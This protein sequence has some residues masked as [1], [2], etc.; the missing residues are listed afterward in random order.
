MSSPCVTVALSPR[1]GNSRPQGWTLAL[2]MSSS[3]AVLYRILGAAAVLAWMKLVFPLITRH[4]LTSLLAD[5]NP[6]QDPI[7]DHVE[8]AIKPGVTWVSFSQ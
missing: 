1:A 4:Y 3:L 6:S 8:P 5:S 7:S 2:V